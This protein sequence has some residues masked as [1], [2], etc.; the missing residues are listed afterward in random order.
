MIAEYEAPDRDPLFDAP[1]MYGLGQA[2]KH[3]P[4]MQTIC[5]LTAAPAFCPVVAPFYAGMEVT[6]AL[7]SDEI[8]GDAAKIAEVYRS[9]YK[10]GSGA[11]RFAETAGENKIH[12]HSR[13]ARKET[14]L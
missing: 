12:H 5:G 14:Q 10:A 11:V 4:E 8:D 3:L 1:R 2:H 6:V 9:C 13:K 7:F